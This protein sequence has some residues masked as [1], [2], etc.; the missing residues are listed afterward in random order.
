MA[1]RIFTCRNIWKESAD[2]PIAC[3]RN[4]DLYLYIFCNVLV[5]LLRVVYNGKSLKEVNVNCESHPSSLKKL[6]LYLLE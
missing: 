5:F 4:E 1:K 6:R 3:K 2:N